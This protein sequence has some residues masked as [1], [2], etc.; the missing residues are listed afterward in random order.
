[1]HDPAPAI[2]AL[3]ATGT[4]ET[5]I[6]VGIPALAVAAMLALRL[7]VG[8]S[9][10]FLLAAVAVLAGLCLIAYVLIA[11][12]FQD[13]DGFVDCWPDCSLLQAAVGVVFWCGGLV[14]LVVGLVATVT[15]IAVMTRGTDGET[16]ARR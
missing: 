12:G 15:V 2:S 7:R 10:S 5:L 4:W 11:A 1:M 6:G 13:A 9:M 8:R 3:A 14:L 16:P